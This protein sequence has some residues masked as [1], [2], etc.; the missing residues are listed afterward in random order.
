MIAIAD[1][2]L[3]CKKSKVKKT[4]VLCPVNTV[5]NWKKEFYKWISSNECDYGVS[6]HAFKFSI[7]WTQTNTAFLTFPPFPGIP[8]DRDQCRWQNQKVT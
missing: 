4:L 8:A 2:L 1:A 6:T 3:T 7:S 5:N